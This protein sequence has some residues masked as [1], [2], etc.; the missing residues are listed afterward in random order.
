[1]IIPTKE[2]CRQAERQCHMSVVCTGCGVSDDAAVDMDWTLGYK[3]GVV[4]N[5]TCNECGGELV[6]PF[7]MPGVLV[8]LDEY[9]AS[10]WWDVQKRLGKC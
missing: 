5:A 3:K 7:M 2:R 9:E 8:I 1:M 4:I 6:A 10:Q